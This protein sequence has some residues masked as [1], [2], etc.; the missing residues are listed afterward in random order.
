MGDTITGDWTLNLT[1]NK[2]NDARSRQDREKRARNKKLQEKAREKSCDKR[3]KTER[4]H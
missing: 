3:H 1:D 4:L 2:A